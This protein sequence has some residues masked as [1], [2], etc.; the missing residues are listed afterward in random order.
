MNINVSELMNQTESMTGT[1]YNKKPLNLISETETE[2]FF[3]NLA[4]TNNEES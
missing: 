4:N 1:S 2:N 3:A